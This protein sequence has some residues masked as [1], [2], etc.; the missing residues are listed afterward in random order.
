MF[1]AVFAVLPV[2]TGNNS[3][4]SIQN[5]KEQLGDKSGIQEPDEYCFNGPLSRA[6]H[7]IFPTTRLI[8][9]MSESRDLIYVIGCLIEVGVGVDF[10]SFAG[11]VSEQDLPILNRETQIPQFVIVCYPEAMQVCL[12]SIIGP[13]QLLHAFPGFC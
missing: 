4:Q 10:C 11:R 6:C 7:L 9:L 2:E 13:K 3:V 12:W 1:D 8:L 5:E